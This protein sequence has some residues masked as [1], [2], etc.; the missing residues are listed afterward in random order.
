MARKTGMM[1]ST[2]VTDRKYR[3][4]Q[5]ER[6]IMKKINCIQNTDDN[7]YTILVIAVL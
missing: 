5:K 7:G 1:G 3:L 2:Y 4:R 6:Q